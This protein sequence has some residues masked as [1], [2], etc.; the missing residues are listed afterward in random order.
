MRTVLCFLLLQWVALIA[1]G[2]NEFITRWTPAYQLYV[3]YTIQFPGVGNNYTIYWEKEGAPGVN[4]TI[5]NANSNHIW[6][7]PSNGTYI[8]KASNGSGSFY[9]FD[10]GRYFGNSNT[11]FLQLL[12]VVQ[13]GNIQ[14]TQL[15]SA[16]YRTAVNV[17]ATDV[18]NLSAAANLSGMFMR[19]ANLVGN[20]SF[21]NWNTANVTSMQGMFSEAPAFNQAIG[22]WNTGGVTDMSH[23]FNFA[24]AFNQNLN[25]NTFNVTNMRSMFRSATQFNGILGSSWNTAAVT[26]MSGMFANA[27]NFNQP[28]ISNWNTAAVTDMS[29]MFLGALAFNQPLNWNTSS[30]TKMAGMFRA[31]HVFNQPLNWNT[32]NVEDMSEMFYLALAYNQPLN[33]NTAKVKN[34]SSMFR[35]ATV[36]NQPLSN[37][38]TSMVTTM[39]YMFRNASGFNQSIGSWN[40]AGVQS[41][42]MIEMLSGSGLDCS[43]YSATLAGWAANPPAPIN[44]NLGA[45]GLVYGSAGQTARNQLIAT[46]GWSFT[47][48]GFTASCALPVTWGKIQAGISNNIL[49]IN[50]ETLSE[51]HCDYFE[52]QIS[53]N[54]DDFTTVG[55]VDSEAVGGYS[56]QRVNY[57]YQIDI[58]TTQFSVISLLGCVLLIFVK[59]SVRAGKLL[60][61]AGIGLCSIAV[62][63]CSKID[64]N[65][66]QGEPALFVRIGQV[67]TDGITRYSPIYKV[68]PK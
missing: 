68:V 62:F 40:I 34:M 52:L 29:L 35:E 63:S 3:G 60:I 27:N 18:P 50:W 5:T 2:Q 14:W 31:A 51:H 4:G 46:R 25:W 48:D 47:G 30:V 54:G 36:F 1:D 12:E 24:A 64:Q 49:E 6:E 45:A 67:D 22:D 11:G 57:R 55:R 7:V 21:A 17:T 15:D 61:G 9:G 8:V 39:A 59:K 23:M 10:A 38:Q 20:S 58:S 19:C 41:G 53:A 33:W 66:I 32:E 65:V 44:I 26:D 42:G 16:F 56:N 28:S 43:N 13:W 37:W